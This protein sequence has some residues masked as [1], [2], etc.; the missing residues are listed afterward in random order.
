M[1]VPREQSK[2]PNRYDTTLL[3]NTH[4]KHTKRAVAKAAALLVPKRDRARLPD[5]AVVM[6]EGLLGN[7]PVGPQIPGEAP[8]VKL[9]HNA[10]HPNIHRDTFHPAKAEKQ[11]ASGH[12]L[13][14]IHISEPT[15]PY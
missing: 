12:L 9:R 2:A 5:G 1:I 15:R 4:L 14:L 11:D 8:G 7:P 13:S 3:K 6:E 10:L